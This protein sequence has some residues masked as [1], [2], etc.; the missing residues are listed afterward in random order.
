MILPLGDGFN[1]EV[2]LH[3]Q[4]KKDFQV[5]N[6]L[7]FHEHVKP[8]WSE[9]DNGGGIDRGSCSDQQLDDARCFGKAGKKEGTKGGLISVDISPFFEQGLYRGLIS[10]HTSDMDGKKVE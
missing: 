6:A 3:D 1:P 5:V 9:A 10:D 7:I 2:Q 8:I 4:G